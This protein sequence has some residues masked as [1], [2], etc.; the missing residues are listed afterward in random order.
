MYCEVGFG[1]HLTDTYEEDIELPI[2]VPENKDSNRKEKR[3][4]HELEVR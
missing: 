1:K 3:L 2:P 4:F